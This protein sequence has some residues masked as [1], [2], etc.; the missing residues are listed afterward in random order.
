MHTFNCDLIYKLIFSLMKHFFKKISIKGLF[1]WKYSLIDD[2]TV[3]SFITIK[4]F[5]Y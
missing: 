3:M 2:F 1:V 4:M 5:Y